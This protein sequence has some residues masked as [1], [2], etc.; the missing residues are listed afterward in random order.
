MNRILSLDAQTLHPGPQPEP[1]R[2]GVRNRGQIYESQ[3]IIGF[4]KQVRR[5]P[6][7]SSGLRMHAGLNFATEPDLFLRFLPGKRSRV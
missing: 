2:E 1:G 7:L 6:G 5:G 4:P 3:P